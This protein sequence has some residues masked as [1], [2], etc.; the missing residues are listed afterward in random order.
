MVFGLLKKKKTAKRKP[1]RRKTTKR[2]V[3]KKGGKKKPFGGY[4]IVPDTKLGAV[5]GNK[6]VT[7]AEMTKKI[8]QYVK[9]NK[10][11]RR[12]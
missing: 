5:I 8:W 2:K 9:R 10:L 12:G 6:A 3:A 1:V 11:S 7:P 4:Q